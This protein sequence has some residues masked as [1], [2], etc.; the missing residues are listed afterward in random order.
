MINWTRVKVAMAAA[1]AFSSTL[2]WA[3]SQEFPPATQPVSWQQE[4]E[5]SAASPPAEVSLDSILFEG[6]SPAT[7]EQLRL[8][9]EHFAE[10]AET[11]KPAVVNIAIGG[12]QG[13]GVV[14]TS[15][16]YILTAAHVIGRPGQQATVTFP[17][18]TNVQATTLG[19][20]T[21]MDSGMLKIK[22]DEGSDWPYLEIGLSNDLDEGHWVM[23]IGHPGGIDKKRG[24]V[25]RVGRIVYQ[26]TNVLR[27]D[28]TLVG[29]DSGGPLVNMNGE[30]IGIHSR[31]GSQLW[32]NLHVPID[33]YSD[34]WDRLAEGIIIDGRAS[35]GFNVVGTTNEVDAVTDFGSAQKAGLKKGDIITRIGSTRVED[36]EDISN[37]MRRLKPFMKT[38]IV[39]ERDGKEQ[40]LDVTVGARR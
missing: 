26:N 22:E 12:A 2:S 33:T 10:L 29:G 1:F 13:S 8:M 39:I 14:V 31:I 16:G 4:S 17:D 19:I 6:R 7:I 36:R 15:D 28:C 5:T 34:N 24:L 3:F 23:A 38:K 40:T 18:G 32:N 20:E 30:V 25:V 9:Q 27:T 37:A 35:L 11:V 21:R